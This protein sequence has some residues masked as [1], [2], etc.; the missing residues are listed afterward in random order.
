ML[1]PPIKQRVRD[2]FDRAATTYD[3]AAVLQRR[4]CDRLLD[5]LTRIEAPRRVLDA[6]CGTGYGS[7]GLCQRWPEAH[8]TGVDFAPAMLE[9]AREQ[10]LEMT[11]SEA[12]APIYVRLSD[13]YS[14]HGSERGE[15]AG[16]DGG[17]NDDS[18]S[19]LAG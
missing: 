4:V 11:Q 15:S 16:A 7:R 6:G 9:L 3:G 8:L 17:R 5:A 2:S 13:G 19:G 12:F 18:A 10:L 14:G 1:S